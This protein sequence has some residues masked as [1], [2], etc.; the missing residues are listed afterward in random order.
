[1]R[2]VRESLEAFRDGHVEAA[3]RFSAPDIVSTRVDPDRA[4]YHGR[5]GVAR[6]IGEWE[7]DFTDMT[8]EPTD[9]VDA[10]DQ[11]VGRLHQSA[12]GAGSGVPVEADFWLV[13]DVGD[14][15]ITRIA[16]YTHRDEAFAAAGLG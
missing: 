1:V 12:K 5:E 2:I 4:V 13:W 10:G 11:V 3:L 14:G 8:Y 15:L 7:E 6:M 16:I 9:L